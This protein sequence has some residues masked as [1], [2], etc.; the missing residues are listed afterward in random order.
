M[1]QWLSVDDIT[2]QP[3]QER[4]LPQITKLKLSLHALPGDAIIH[5]VPRWLGLFPNLRE[6]HLSSWGAYEEQKDSDKV[7]YVR[8]VQDACPKVVVL[9][10]DHVSKRVEQ[11]LEA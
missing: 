2:T 7:A 4:C 5:S 6:V 8:L 10:L 9:R 3:R 11:W 1:A